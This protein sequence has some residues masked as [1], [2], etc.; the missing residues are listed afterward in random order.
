MISSL[1]SIFFNWVAQALH[2][3]HLTVV[4][5]ASKCWTPLEFTY[6]DRMAG[7]GLMSLVLGSWCRPRI[8]L[9]AEGFIPGAWDEDFIDGLPTAFLLLDF[10]TGVAFLGGSKRQREVGLPSRKRENISHQTRKGHSFSKV[11]WEQG[12]VSSQRS[13]IVE[14]NVSFSSKKGVCDEW[15]KL[16]WVNPS[17]MKNM[18]RHHGSMFWC[19]LTLHSV[20]LWSRKRKTRHDWGLCKADAYK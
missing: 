3:N 18:Y 9:L 13:R 14:Q 11:P 5:N 2:T 10:W 7:L 20:A 16:D 17:G 15:I 19:L 12:Y 6:L 1:T 4:P 8:V